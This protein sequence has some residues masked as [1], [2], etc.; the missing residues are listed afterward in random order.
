MKL[1]FW[2]SWYSW[3][4]YEDIEKFDKL[5]R[6]HVTQEAWLTL[7]SEM[8]DFVFCD[9]FEFFSFVMKVWTFRD[10]LANKKAP[11][12]VTFA[13]QTFRQLMMEKSN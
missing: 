3:Q 7:S 11:I 9:L 1:A 12:Q 4:T 8:F 2:K 5:F 6:L 13:V 10:E